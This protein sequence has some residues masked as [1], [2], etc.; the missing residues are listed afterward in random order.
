MKEFGF[1]PERALTYSKYLK[2][3]SPEKPLSVIAFFRNQQFT[4]SEISLIVNQWPLIFKRNVPDSSFPRKIEFFRNLGM[5][6]SELVKIL[7][8]QGDLLGGSL[9]RQII[10]VVEFLRSFLGSDRAVMASI[11]RFPRILRVNLQKTLLPNV[12]ILRE[13]GVPESHIAHLLKICSILIALD[14]E[15][16]R[17]TTEEVLGLGINP[18]TKNFILGL[19]VKRELSRSS[20]KEKIEFYTRWGWSE[21]Q[22]LETIRRSPQI[23]SVSQDK[24]AKIMDLITKKM[25]RDVSLF[26]SRPILLSLSFEKRV[27]PRC[28]FYQALLSRGLVRP[29]SLGMMLG[30]TQRLFLEKYVK[31]FVEKDPELQKVYEEIFSQSKA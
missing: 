31:Q 14:P 29:S 13:V 16:F 24:S 12:G 6:R 22:F 21:D 5:S 28:A 18:K 30:S 9:D 19:K 7:E 26:M 10:P 17:L 25:G 23:M 2:F 20:W 15:C 3:D 11:L 27:V 8:L 4:D 1:S